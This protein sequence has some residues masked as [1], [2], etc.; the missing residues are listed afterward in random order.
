[1]S[2]SLAPH[3]TQDLLAAH[4]GDPPALATDPF[5]VGPGALL[6]LLILGIV[7][8][9]AIGHV[10]ALVWAVVRQAL[11]VLGILALGLGMVVLVGMAA[12]TQKGEKRVSP[13]PSTVRSAPRSTARPRPPRATRTRATPPPLVPLPRA[14]RARGDGRH[15]PHGRS[16]RAGRAGRVWVAGR[17][18]IEVSSRPILPGREGARVD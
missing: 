6:L 2:V 12:V 15:V 13:A 8:V 17:S 4:A 10:L 18:A 11:P 3:Q 16:L 14:D 1:M 9:A 7:L 5:A